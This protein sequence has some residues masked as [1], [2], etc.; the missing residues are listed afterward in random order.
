MS[1]RWNPVANMEA[2]AAEPVKRFADHDAGFGQ[3][4]GGLQASD[5][6]H[7]LRVA[8]PRL[9]HEL[10]LVRCAADIL[11]DPVTVKVPL[12]SLALPGTAGPPMSPAAHGAGSAP[13]TGIEKSDVAA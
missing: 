4:I 10:E 5:K 8:G 6:G 9:V 12:A 3:G 1:I 13:K 7:D 11:P 2:C